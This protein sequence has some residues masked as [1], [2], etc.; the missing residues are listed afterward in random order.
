MHVI[1]FVHIKQ[2]SKVSSRLNEFFW[3]RGEIQLRALT[4]NTGQTLTLGQGRVQSE[5]V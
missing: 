4:F 1:L 2:P 3:G 5:K